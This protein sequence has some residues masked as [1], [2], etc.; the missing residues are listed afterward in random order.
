MLSAR[1]V[2]PSLAKRSWS[3]VGHQRVSYRAVVDSN[4]T[5]QPAIVFG[6]PPSI[7]AP[8][9]LTVFATYTRTRRR[10]V[11]SGRTRFASRLCRGYRSQSANVRFA[12]APSVR[13]A[14]EVAEP[15][16]EAPRIFTFAELDSLR[17][18][19][20]S[21]LDLSLLMGLLGTDQDFVVVEPRSQANRASDDSTNAT[22]LASRWR[23]WLQSI[24]LGGHA[25]LPAVIDLEQARGL[26]LGLDAWVPW[27]WSDRVAAELGDCANMVPYEGWRQLHGKSWAAA[28]LAE[29]SADHGPALRD[30][31][32]VRLEDS[33]AQPVVC[34]TEED[35]FAAIGELPRHG[36]SGAYVKAEFGWAGCG[37][38]RLRASD[39]QTARDQFARWLR[40]QLLD[41]PVVVE[42]EFE[43]VFDFSVQLDVS[44]ETV[45]NMHKI[46]GTGSP[47]PNVVAS[48]TFIVDGRGV[49]RGTELARDALSSGWAATFLG[50]A[51]RVPHLAKEVTSFMVDSVASSVGAT[52]QAHGY[53]GPA[54][55]DGFAY[56]HPESRELCIRPICDI[57]PRYTMSRLAA[58]A[59]WRWTGEGDVAALRVLPRA[60][61]DALWARVFGAGR[62]ASSHS[63]GVA[64]PAEVLRNEFG[65]TTPAPTHAGALA[66]PQHRGARPDAF[67]VVPLTPLGRPPT[68]K[69]PEGLAVMLLIAPD[70]T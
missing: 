36:W 25:G 18:Q 55:V 33:I 28:R 50:R 26:E 29:W 14:C 52:L 11:G 43:R 40:R 58:E 44:D 31:A 27:L 5:L 63:L 54:G 21:A 30:L 6:V 68:G 16:S 39:K 65:M 70:K 37:N 53:R 47:H 45:P 41:G 22:E 3:S 57:N 49:Y 23:D 59:A 60:R 10:F 8:V 35:V 64:V 13:L 9:A 17:P 7:L 24:G 62:V 32:G 69:K 4:E 56:L 38:R 66:S 2:G 42:P 48:H 34:R 19:N 15:K 67:H 61:A 20:D 1:H 51:G 12:T 46:N